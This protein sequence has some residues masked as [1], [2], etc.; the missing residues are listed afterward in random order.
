MLSVLSVN[1]LA[2]MFHFMLSDMENISDSNLGFGS[3]YDNK[4]LVVVNGNVVDMA[5]VNKKPCLRRCLYFS[6][7]TYIYV[8]LWYQHSCGKAVLIDFWN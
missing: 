7:N 3:E 5:N 8:E 4:Y 1:L 6:K 2:C